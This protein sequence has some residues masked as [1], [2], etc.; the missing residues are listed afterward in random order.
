[1]VWRWARV[2]LFNLVCWSL[3]PLLAVAQDPANKPAPAP[4]P[5]TAPANAPAEAPAIAVPGPEIP[6]PDVPKV[7]VP[8]TAD[9]TPPDPTI[10][11]PTPEHLFD[12]P[13]EASFRRREPEPPPDFAYEVAAPEKMPF[14]DRAHL[15]LWN[16][17]WR[18]AMRMDGSGGCSGSWRRRTASSSAGGL[19]SNASC[20]RRRSRW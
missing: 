20:E 3:L 12:D 8:G 7:N 5:A 6:T 17:V 1:M 4:P 13:G 19:A 15:G 18:S 14:I 9:T 16:T 11:N 2:N 10:I